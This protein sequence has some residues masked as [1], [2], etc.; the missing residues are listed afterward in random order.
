MGRKLLSETRKTERTSRRRGNAPFALLIGAF[1]G[2]PLLLLAFSGATPPGYTG[3]PADGSV[4]CASC[5]N[6]YGAANSD[7]TGSVSIV[8]GDYSPGVQQTLKVIVKHPTATRWGFQ[9]T[10]RS[11]NDPALAAGNFAAAD[12]IAVVCQSGLPAPCNGPPE[13]AGHILTPTT[14]ATGS[15]EFDVVWNP[16]TSEVG[17]IVFYVSA[18]AA[19]GN[20]LPT[21]DRVYAASATVSLAAGA[22]CS[23]ARPALRT[24]QNGASFLASFSPGSMLTIFGSG[25]QSSGH[26]RTAGPGDYVGNTFPTVLGCVSVLLNGQLAPVTYLNPTQ[27]NVQAPNLTATGPVSL[28][29]VAN[30]GKATEI[31][32]DLATLPDVQPYAPAFFTFNGM[33]TGSIAAQF[34]GTA[35]PVANAS[36]VAGGRAAKPGD[37]ITLYGA[38]FG[39]TTPV[40]AAG[41]LDPG[42]SNVAAPVTVSIGG[43]TLASSDVLYAG[44][45]PG[46]ISGLYQFN[47]RVPMS[48]SNGDV[49]V[50]IQVGGYTTQNNVTI[51]VQ[52]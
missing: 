24:A 11:M 5:H 16:P 38:G 3:A 6:T 49:P 15:Y 2:V 26:T 34:A 52:Q 50:S 48:A 1:A 44:L 30:A 13:F 8:T 7:S 20:M 41:A 42:I 37:I 32:S 29:V 47:V 4:T 31:R 46:S 40:V 12:N 19:D 28:V 23:L 45:S 39:S 22:G 9:L 51:P 14:G 21:N 43:V 18:V 35:I 10:A 33:G 27:I 17:R 25:F 36:V